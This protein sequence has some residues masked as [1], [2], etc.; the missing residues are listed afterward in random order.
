MH[1]IQRAETLFCLVNQYK[2]TLHTLRPPTPRSRAWIQN[3]KIRPDGQHTARL[4]WA[5]L[6]LLLGGNHSDEILNLALTHSPS[7]LELFSNE[8]HYTHNGTSL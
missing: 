2:C 6:P 8:A 3:L 1:L 4:P 5:S 7:Q